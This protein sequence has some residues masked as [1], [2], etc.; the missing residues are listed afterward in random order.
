MRNTPITEQLIREYIEKNLECSRVINYTDLHQIKGFSTA[1]YKDLPKTVMN[2]YPVASDFVGTDGTAYS[3]REFAQLTAKEQAKCKL[4]Y[5]YLPKMHELYVGTTGSGKTTGC[6]EPQLRAISSQKNKP[7]LFVTDPKGE[8]FDRNAKHLQDQG[9][10]LYVLNFKEVTRSDRWN[11]LLDLYDLKMQIGKIGEGKTTCAGPVDSELKKMD[12]DCLYVGRYIVYQGM[13]FASEATYEKYL[14]FEKDC[15]EAEIASSVNQIANMMIKVQSKHDKSWEFGAQDL[16]KGLIYCLLEEAVDPESGFTRDM[17]TL[18]TLQEYYTILRND[19]V[20][21]GDVSLDGHWLTRNKPSKVLSF[22]RTAMG[23][24]SNTMKSYCGVFDGALKDWFQAHIF[25]LTTGNTV[26]IEELGDTPFAIFLITR[27]YEK[28]DFLIAGLFVDWLYKKMVVKAEAT[29]D[30]KEMHFLLDEFGNVPEISDMENKIST[31]RSRNIWFHLVVQSYMQIE[32]V[33]GKERSVIFRDNCNGQIFLGAQNR[34]TKEIFSEEC[35]I[36]HIEALETV[37]GETSARSLVKVPLIPVSR[38]DEIDPG[39]MYVKR[40]Y[41]PT[42]T[43]QFIRSYICA[44]Q[45]TYKDFNDANGI[46]TCTPLIIDPFS[47]EK[48]TFKKLH[49]ERHK[50][51]DYDSFDF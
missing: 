6:V 34:K 48:Y 14:V 4:R 21:S 37:L 15:L 26:N 8:L 51:G 35:G 12:K 18:R 2:G 38:L 33:Y 44:N 24:A 13:A 25:A 7:N 32:L 28:S 11:P 39:Q 47:G 10:K 20:S 49:I 17:M 40:L 9:Y 50:R 42:I 22:M 46:A 5:Y 23:N 29:K 36:H 27:D 43:S 45:G 3:V 1:F 30:P 31:S 16:L 19:I 41:T